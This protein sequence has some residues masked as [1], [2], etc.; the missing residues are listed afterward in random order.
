MPFFDFRCEECGH[1]FIKRV[2]NAEKHQVE[3]PEC[4]HRRVKQLLSPFFTSGS[5]GDSGPIIPDGCMGCS[6]AGS[7]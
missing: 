7:G 5:S 3:C 2:S 4:G 1:Q 6:Q